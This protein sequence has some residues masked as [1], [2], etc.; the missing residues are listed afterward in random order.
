MAHIGRPVVSLELYRRYDEVLTADVELALGLRG[1]QEQLRRLQELY[2]LRLDHALPPVRQLMARKGRGAFLDEHR[3]AAISAVRTLDRQHVQRIHKL[4]REFDEQWRPAKRPA[5]AE[6][7][8]ELGELLDGAAVLAVAGGHV[9]VLAT[10][11]RLFDPLGLA[12]GRIP[13]VAW[14]AGAMVLTERIVLFHDRPPQG[15]GNPEV[16]EPG[17]G[18]VKSLVALPHAA[19]RLRLGDPVRVAAFARRFSPAASVA[20][21]EGSRLLIRDDHWLPGVNT[22]AL[23][24][25]GKVRRLVR[26]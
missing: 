19:S 24:R 15:A 12:A 7:R 9:A 13:L 25:S 11:M 21:D 1:R 26:R 18:L 17:F 3:R 4:H 2:R 16:L 8:R 23:G 6:H 5:V 14:S 22:R 10:R 20:L